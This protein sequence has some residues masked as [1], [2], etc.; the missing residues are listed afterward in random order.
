M[1]SFD[2]FFLNIYRLG[3]ILAAGLKGVIAWHPFLAFGHHP[4][5]PLL[6]SFPKADCENLCGNTE[7]QTPIPATTGRA[8]EQHG[9]L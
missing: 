7:K 1:N 6:V 2:N 9:T 4:K 3:T 8:T 5:L